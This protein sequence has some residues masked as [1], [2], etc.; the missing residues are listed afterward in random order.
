MK[1]ERINESQIRCTLSDTDLNA[2][3]LN[4]GELAYGSEKTRK[5]FHEMLQKA[6]LE[7]G[8]ETG[9]L[10]LMVEAIPITGES[11]V[12]IITKV[13]DPE[14]IDTRFAKF[15][16]YMEEGNITHMEFD[17]FEVLEGTE[18]ISGTDKARVKESSPDIH[19]VFIF[20]SLD[21]CSDAAKAAGNN[22]YGTSRLYKNPLDSVYLL[23]LS[24]AGTNSLDFANICNALAEYGKKTHTNHLGI[25]F[26]EEHYELIIKEKAMETLSRL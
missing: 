11:V 6:S 8:F 5:L 17:N 7:V 20:D 15:S 22:F 23:V 26:Y 13:E 9:N 12:V 25:A 21:Q 14:E 24:S 1:I 3:D 19:K 2:R 10:P 16:P 18:S 4:I